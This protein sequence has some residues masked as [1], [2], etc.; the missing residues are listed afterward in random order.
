[1]TTAAAGEIWQEKIHGRMDEQECLNVLHFQTVMGANNVENQLLAALLNCVVTALL[2]GMSVNYKFESITAMRVSPTVGPE[3]S[4]VPDPSGLV[5][6]SAT[7]DSLPSFNS[8]VLSIRANAGGRA[9]RGRI[10]LAG[11]PEGSSSGSFLSP[12][13]PYFQAAVAFAL[14]MLNA[15]KHFEDIPSNNEFWFGVMSRKIGGAKP[16]FLAAGFS[17]VMSIEAKRLIATTRSRKVG[18]G[19]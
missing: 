9:G 4:R 19:S 2:P 8:C 12:E 3:L 5:Q 17:K 7:G 6:G 13:S 14:C 15:F 18:H 11:I 16:P 10:F 1:M